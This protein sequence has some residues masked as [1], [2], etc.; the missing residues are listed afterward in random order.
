MLQRQGLL[1]TCGC[2]GL[3]RHKSW[4]LKHCAGP[5]RR[6]ASDP[7][8]GERPATQ[9]CEGTAGSRHASAEQ[10]PAP[11]RPFPCPAA[12]GDS[13]TPRPA[14]NGCS[15]CA[16]RTGKR[17]F[18]HQFELPSGIAFLSSTLR[19]EGQGGDW[20]LGS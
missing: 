14:G 3:A 15:C 2:T 1:Y 19:A 16:G 5:K 8:T 4:G 12:R 10:H 13:G 7:C 6:R 11:P 9:Q 20:S 18:R 17:A